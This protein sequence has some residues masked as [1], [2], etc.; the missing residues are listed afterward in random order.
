[1]LMITKA[2]LFGCLRSPNRCSLDAYD[3]EIET[4]LMLMAVKW[5]LFDACGCEIGAL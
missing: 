4:L 5:A 2:T 1:M 3:Y